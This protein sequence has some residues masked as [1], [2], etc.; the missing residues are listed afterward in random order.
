MRNTFILACVTAAVSACASYQSP[1]V[2]DGQAQSDARIASFD[3]PSLAA[4][5]GQSSAPVRSGPGVIDSMGA[6]AGV[7]PT[8]YRLSLSMED[9][10]SQTV[11][12]QNPTFFEGERVWV[13]PEGSVEGL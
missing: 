4:A 2:A 9:G 1:S 3:P 5:R 10:A 13:S 8:T 12:V 7:T 11:D 6:L